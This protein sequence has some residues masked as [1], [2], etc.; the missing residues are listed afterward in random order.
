MTLPGETKRNAIAVVKAGAADRTPLVSML[1]RAFIDDPIYLW[2]ISG[3]AKRLQALFGAYLDHLALKH[4]ET[5]MTADHLGAA[6]WAPPGGWHLGL[7]EEILFLPDWLKVIGLRHVW[8]RWC[9]V[10][11]IQKLHPETPHWYLMVIGIAPEAQGQG[12][13]SLLLNPVLDRCDSTGM[14]AYLETA[15]PSNLPLY[16]RFG[17][18]VTQQIRVPGGP[19]L[20]LMWREPRKTPET[21]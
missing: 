20:W 15:T 19:E 10:E 5:F 12:R 11:M 17:F 3:N 16:R 7:L 9:A 4:D 21:C 13:A 2:L 14:P 6:L 18:E 1:A 8:S